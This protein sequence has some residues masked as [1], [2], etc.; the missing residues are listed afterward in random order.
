[1][2]KKVVYLILI[3]LIIAVSATI[4]WTIQEERLGNILCITSDDVENKIYM[5]EDSGKEHR[6][7]RLDRNGN[8]EIAQKLGKY[9]NERYFLQQCIQVDGDGRL[10]YIETEQDMK[11]QAVLVER[12]VRVDADGNGKQV[13][14]EEVKSADQG[15]SILAIQIIGRELV[16]YQPSDTSTKV[17]KVKKINIDTP[18][19]NPLVRS[20]DYLLPAE[21]SSIWFTEAE[22]ILIVTMDSEM[23]L[24]DQKDNVNRL[25]P[26]GEEL[27]EQPV[28]LRNVN[29]TGQVYFITGID[30]A[31]RRLNT[32]DGSVRD[33]AAS[34]ALI[35]DRSDVRY[36]D[37][38]KYSIQDNGDISWSITYQDAQGIFSIISTQA[39]RV[40]SFGKITF[41]FRHILKNFFMILAL[42]LL[43]GGI[44]FSCVVLI[45]KV[46][47]GRTSIYLKQ[48]LIFMPCMAVI[49]GVLY[50]TINHITTN[51]M[52][53]ETYNHLYYTCRSNLKTLAPELFRAMESPGQYDRAA[54]NRLRVSVDEWITNDTL[55]EMGKTGN[56]DRIAKGYTYNWLYIVR[57][58]RIFA[59]ATTLYPI[60]TPLEYISDSYTQECFYAAVKENKTVISELSDD[61][62]DWLFIV[63]PV[64]DQAGNV[65]G[66]YEIGTSKTSYEM[67]VKN[68]SFRIALLNFGMGIMMMGAF[69]IML[70]VSLKPMKKL[71]NAV[72]T[73]SEGNYDIQV[74]I[75]STDEIADIGRMFNAMARSIRNNLTLLK[76]YNESYYRFVPER[77]FHILNKPDV[78]DVKMGDQIKRDMTIM[79][80]NTRRFFEFSSKMETKQIFDLINEL[81]SM[82]V[83]VVDGLG[84]VIDRYDTAGFISLFPMDTGNAVE[85]ALIIREKLMAYN[86]TVLDR[87]EFADQM[88]I[89]IAINRGSVMV[90]VVG[91]EKRVAATAI[92]QQV[93]M[94]FSLEALGEEL[95]CSVVLTQQA[96]EAITQSELLNYRYIGTWKTSDKNQT[97]IYDF[98]DGDPEVVRNG[99]KKTKTMFLEA[100]A[101]FEAQD[102]LKA[103]NLFIEVL[104]HNTHDGVARK[105][106]LI[107]DEYCKGNVM[108]AKNGL[109]TN[110]GFGTM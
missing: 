105:Y 59:V 83:P 23:Y 5:I 74:S 51:T 65:V 15:Q 107:C 64:V 79:Y 6:L 41:P 108:A 84:G 47:K 48:V 24:L 33:I 54:Y 13:L 55:Y 53:E 10:Y 49:M 36:S 63:S 18:F 11:T 102:Y 28:I 38:F 77:L 100:I 27:V 103:R 40:F 56:G 17:F 58:N 70:K 99:K 89:G 110:P 50:F 26:K 81:Y 97:S 12:I 42:L 75:D 61:E 34:T 67:L 31:L 104:K 73:V 25:W 69:L 37:L 19:K 39:G 71:K 60:F 4:L 14:Y 109:F 96:L 45:R 32:A 29:D 87:Q 44:V 106:L 16:F 93:N 21:Y 35:S 91:Q 80:V 57:D 9:G 7:L 52:N 76:A 62:G 95:E 88:E 98:F 92:S 22:D 85:A 46:T 2:K 78:I 66:L 68:N 1:M 30:K 43:A 82:F 90:G 3:A 8:V 86:K 94:A 20:V 101:G 72:A